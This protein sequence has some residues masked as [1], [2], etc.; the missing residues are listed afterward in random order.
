[1]VAI[2]DYI[3]NDNKNNN[4]SDGDNENDNN[5]IFFIKWVLYPLLQ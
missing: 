4:D 3:D 2:V 5:F 1:M